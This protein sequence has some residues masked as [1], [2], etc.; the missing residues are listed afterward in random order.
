MKAVVFDF[1]YTLVNE[2]RVWGAI[3]AQD[4][5]S[6]SVFFATLRGA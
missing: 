2:D 3:A 4:G 6:A 1:G 5:W